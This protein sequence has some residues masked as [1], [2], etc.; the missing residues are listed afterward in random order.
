[1][2]GRWEVIYC[3][4]RRL[5]CVNNLYRAILGRVFLPSFNI[6]IGEEYLLTAYDVGTW[7]HLIPI[8]Y[9]EIL[10][11]SI[12]NVF[13]RI[14]KKTHFN[15]CCTYYPFSPSH[16]SKD[17]LSSNLQLHWKLLWVSNQLPPSLLLVQWPRNSNQSITLQSAV[18]YHSSLLI[19]RLDEKDTTTH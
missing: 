17:T 15:F 3:C 13:R 10:E 11:T 7:I 18:S 2:W 14:P 9:R 8:R 12:K 1:M 19:L 6:E 16:R 5:F 4:W